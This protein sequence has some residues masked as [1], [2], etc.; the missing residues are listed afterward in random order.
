MR[1]IDLISAPVLCV[2]MSGCS[3]SRIR[4][5]GMDLR[6][7]RSFHVASCYVASFHVSWPQPRRGSDLDQQDGIDRW[8]DPLIERPHDLLIFA[9]AASGASGRQRLLPLLV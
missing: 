4:H 5:G 8:P 2:S 1:A 9:L 7:A 6:S 3:V